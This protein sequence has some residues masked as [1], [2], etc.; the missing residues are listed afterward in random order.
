MNKK[1]GQAGS[2]VPP[3]SPG[4]PHEADNANPGEVESVKREQ[5]QTKTGKYGSVKATPFNAENVRDPTKETSWI[6]VEL[7]GED[8]KPIPGERYRVTLPDGSVAEGSLDQNGMA[9][10]EG[11]EPGSCKVTFPDLDQDAWEPA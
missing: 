5:R 10:V 11:F 8:G 6:E 4:D 9:R 1:T 7:V 2:I 3:Q